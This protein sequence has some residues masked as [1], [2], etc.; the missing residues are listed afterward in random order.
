MKERPILFSA[1]M[2]RAILEGRKTQTRRIVKPQRH[3]FGHMLAADEVAKEVIGQTCAVRCPYGKPGDRLW[4]REKHLNWWNNTD[5]PTFSH[6]AAYAA[7]GYELQP[8]EKW[9]PSIHMLRA[10][11]RIN[12]E[13]TG[14]RVERLQDIRPSDCSAEGIVP[15]P[16]PGYRMN[17]Y[18]LE[19]TDQDDAHPTWIAAYR[20]L[21][22]SINGSGSW[23]ASPWVWV[24]EFRRVEPASV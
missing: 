15:I 8:G 10:A 16:R 11:S 24:V 19:G 20:A 4:V 12:L 23:D 7:D 14:I 1:P 6:V 13:I 3:P 21:W 17:G 22:E 5:P 2:V 18:G 9:I